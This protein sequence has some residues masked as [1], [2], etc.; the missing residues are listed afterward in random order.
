MTEF[1][2]QGRRIAD[3]S[4]VPSGPGH[5]RAPVPSGS[6]TLPCGTARSKPRLPGTASDADA[7]RDVRRDVGESLEDAMAGFGESVGLW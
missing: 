4:V 5:R 3:I 2:G 1:V 6:S 7:I